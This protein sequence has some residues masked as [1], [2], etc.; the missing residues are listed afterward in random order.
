MAKNKKPRK[1]KDC[2]CGFCK[3]EPGKRYHEKYGFDL[4]AVKDTECLMC[5]KLIGN[6]EY[7]LDVGL[8]R[9]GNVFV[10]HKA[11]A[12]KVGHKEQK[13]KTKHFDNVKGK[14]NGEE[15]SKT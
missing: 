10:L 3:P 4:D 12:E 8:A 5:R 1:E 7:E 6:A 13:L 11:C 2:T 9:F 14:N 15:K